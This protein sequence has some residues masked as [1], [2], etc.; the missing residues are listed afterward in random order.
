MSRTTEASAELLWD[1]VSSDSFTT[2][3]INDVPPAKRN[4]RCSHDRQNNSSCSL[5]LNFQV[6]EQ[7]ISEQ[8]KARWTEPVACWWKKASDW[9][10][11]PG[12]SGNTNLYLPLD[13]R[14][15][16][17]DKTPDQ[18]QMSSDK[19][20]SFRSSCVFLWFGFSYNGL[21]N[22]PDRPAGLNKPKVS[23]VS[24][25]SGPKATHEFRNFR[26]TFLLKQL[27]NTALGPL[28]GY[29]FNILQDRAM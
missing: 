29:Y 7:F 11:S 28:W 9:W 22:V 4:P 14:N 25:G 16:C 5:E 3:L 15:Q 18:N 20:S 8:L 1:S 24:L 2:V 12:S 10:T 26:Q 13:W 6:L 23:A 19:L 27:N 21:W 17:R